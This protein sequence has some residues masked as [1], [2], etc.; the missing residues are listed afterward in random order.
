MDGTLFAK[1]FQLVL[2]ALGLAYGV[3]VRVE[4]CLTCGG[5]RSGI[6]AGRTSAPVV[7]RP[8]H[9]VE[10]HE[11]F[12]L[13][14]RA[15]R[16]D[17]EFVYPGIEDKST[18][19]MA[20]AAMTL[21]RLELHEYL[22]SLRGAAGACAAAEESGDWPAVVSDAACGEC[23]ASSQC[24]IPAELR[25]HRGTINTVSRRRRRRRCWTGGVRRMRRSTCPR[26]ASTCGCWTRR[27]PS[28]SGRCRRRRSRGRGS[29]GCDL[30][31]ARVRVAALAVSRC[32]TQWTEECLP[33]PGVARR[34]R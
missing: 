32:R 12:P 26:R 11:P 8:R 25:D 30:E 7:R 14:G 22:E 13:A 19:L 15:Q 27:R 17:L 1:N 29:Y 3:P 6:A 5:R 4:P 28:R 2:Y 10:I 34:G 21:T 23:P 9:R 16:F 24:P 33:P 18:G 31:G 20:R